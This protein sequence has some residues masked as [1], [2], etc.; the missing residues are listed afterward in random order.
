MRIF[1]LNKGDLVM[2]QI[3]N[4][5]WIITNWKFLRSSKNR[6]ICTLKNNAGKPPFA[7]RCY[8]VKLLEKSLVRA[9]ANFI[10]KLH[11]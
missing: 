1:T 11:C 4:V 5:S 10:G 9:I 7:H 3:P 8:V 6:S 2:N